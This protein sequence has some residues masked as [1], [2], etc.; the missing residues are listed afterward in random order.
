LTVFVSGSA[1]C[2]KAPPGKAAFA[3]A[4]VKAALA[5][6]RASRRVIFG[7]CIVIPLLLPP[8]AGAPNERQ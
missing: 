2:A 8:S 1:F 3:A 5:P 6:R 4:S 7:V